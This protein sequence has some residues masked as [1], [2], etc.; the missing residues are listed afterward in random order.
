MNEPTT[1]PTTPDPAAGLG[2]ETGTVGAMR[3][4]SFG[5]DATP[6]YT[7]P[8]GAI[9]IDLRH[10]YPDLSDGGALTMLT[11]AD[12]PVLD[13][14]RST[15]GTQLFVASVFGTVTSLVDYQPGRGP[16]IALP[17]PVVAFG[18]DRGRHRSVAMA[19]LLAHHA[20]LYSWGAVV[21]HAHLAPEDTPGGAQ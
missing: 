12:A 21:V 17:V 19:E 1:R 9:V 10:W 8:P 3:V 14:V 5:Y 4:E 2:A 15:Q 11:G 16:A 20:R 6:T 18:S 13:R 7:P